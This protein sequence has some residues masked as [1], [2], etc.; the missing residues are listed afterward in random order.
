MKFRG[1]IAAVAVSSAAFAQCGDWVPTYGQYQLTGLDYDLHT[2]IEAIDHDGPGP[3]PTMVYRNSI[4]AYGFGSFWSGITVYCPHPWDVRLPFPPGEIAV[5]AILAINEPTARLPAG[6]LVLASNYVDPDGRDMRI[7]AWDGFALRGIGPTDPAGFDTW[8]PQ[9]LIIWDPDGEGPGEPVLVAAGGFRR[10]CGVDA[11]HVAFWN[12]QIWAQLAGGLVPIPEQLAVFDFDA[13]GPQPPRLVATADED[14]GVWVCDGTQWTALGLT[15]AHAIASHDPDGSG[16]LP[17]ELYVADHGFNSVDH[18]KKWDGQEWIPAGY[19]WPS[20]YS[21]FVFR[22]FSADLDDDGPQVP[23]LYAAG[24]FSE[25]VADAP[26]FTFAVRTE[27]GWI[28]PPRNPIDAVTGSPSGH[29]YGIFDLAVIDPDGPGPRSNVVAAAGG[30][31]K[32][33]TL[34]S[35][36]DATFPAWTGSE[37][38]SVHPGFSSLPVWNMLPFDADGPGPEPARLYATGYF[39]VVDSRETAS[40]AVWRDGGWRS[41]GSQLDVLGTRWLVEFDS[42]GA[43][44]E[45]PWLVGSSNASRPSN[46]NRWTGSSWVPVGDL[47]GT[48]NVVTLCGHDEDGEGP[49]PPT[50]FIGGSLQGRVMRLVGNSWVPAGAPPVSTAYWLQNHD[51]DGDGPEPPMLIVC[52]IDG[53]M[54][55]WVPGSGTWAPYAVGVT[56]SNIVPNVAGYRWNALSW[57]TDGPG[58]RPTEFIICARDITTPQGLFHGAAAYNGTT[59]R[60]LAAG[61]PP[62]AIRSAYVIDLDGPGPAPEEVFVCGTSGIGRLHNG[63]WEVIPLVALG[64]AGYTPGVEGPEPGEIFV[65]GEFTSVNGL[66]ATGFARWRFSDP[67]PCDADVNCDGAID[68]AD[69]QAMEQAVN[70]NAADY[71]QSETDFNRDGALNGFDIEA[72]ESVVN[73]GPCP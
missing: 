47:A 45:I 7:A 28:L 13:D 58:P 56:V 59:W 14:S 64:L 46:I 55:R 21:N 24:E 18:I 42:D 33:H 51:R 53:R 32:F 39:Y 65:C 11:E 66:I 12:G 69:V 23:A 36:G 73:G 61:S 10:L 38:E 4:Y 25:Q 19:G 54:G 20:N 72:V 48:N 8:S 35:N 57:D 43:G 37:F 68:G 67:C 41:T 62:G 16:P 40:L 49:L 6:T 15:K 9:V 5:P 27:S 34:R 2:Q 52:D 17:S 3:M 63:E 71:C 50:L 44:P 60:G 30:T 31:T 26:T 22:L 29:A 70:G 1:A